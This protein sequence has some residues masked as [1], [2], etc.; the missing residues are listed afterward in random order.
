MTCR[1]GWSSFYFFCS[2]ARVG[3]Y[4][5]WKEQLPQLSPDTQMPPVL[6]QRDIVHLLPGASVNAKEGCTVGG[7][8]EGGVDVGCDLGVVLGCGEG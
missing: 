4:L 6:Q 1:A 5:G 8:A 2:S 7:E 3:K